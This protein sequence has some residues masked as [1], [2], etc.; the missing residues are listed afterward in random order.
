M[1][2][3]VS[4]R[5]ESSSVAVGKRILVL[6]DD[7]QFCALVESVLVEDGYDVVLAGSGAEATEKLDDSVSLAVVDGF[8]PDARGVE[9]IVDARR[10][11]PALPIIFVSGFLSDLGSY[12]TLTSDLSVA[13]VIY[14]PVPPQQIAATI[15][16]VLGEASSPKAKRASR[17]K[18]VKTELA[19]KLPGRVEALSDHVRAL[20]ERPDDPERLRVV[21]T[22]SHNLRGTA[23][24]LGYAAAGDAAGRIEDT[25]RGAAQP[26][27]VQWAIIDAAMDEVR[28]AVRRDPASPEL[29][30]QT[31]ASLCRILVVDDDA[32]FLRGLSSMARRSLVDIVPAHGADAAV[33]VSK[34][35]APDA[36]LID[37]AVPGEDTFQLA[38][39]LRELDGLERL[40]IGFISGTDS[41]LSRT[42]A[43]L[44][45]ASLFLPKPLEEGEFEQAVQQLLRERDQERSRVLIVDDDPLLSNAIARVLRNRG[46]VARTLNDPSLVLEELN[47]FAPHAMLLDGSMPVFSGYDVCRAVRLSARWRTLPILFVTG[48]STEYARHAAFASGGDDY[49]QKPVHLPEL[50]SRLEVRL[51][52]ARLLDDR[53]GRD[54]LSGLLSRQGFNDRFHARLSE[55]AR[56]SEQVSVCLIDLDRFKQVNDRH[57]HI[58]GDR[59]IAA[60]GLMLRRR[61]RPYDLRARWGGEEFLLALPGEGAEA[62]TEIVRRTLEEFGQTTFEGQAGNTFSVTFSA[63]VATYPDDG[64][65]LTQLI[66]SA[67]ERLYQAKS[68]GRRSVRGPG[69]Q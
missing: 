32:E 66:G 35:E 63:G 64:T 60:F 49:L 11:H 42:E 41:I 46:H 40:P 57:G 18:R 12:V 48:D 5:C 9:W 38:R 47:R 52:R 36:V 15:G 24:S 7:P 69:P 10:R 2:G 27:D 58:V 45:G 55:A 44:C 50:C 31:P 4:L 3:T 1:N 59:V 29:S 62:A 65:S 20:R 68:A 16:R 23:G 26:S 39:T 19:A 22:E 30:I 67:D 54:A 25:L 34:R 51:D 28:Q 33:E 8:L 61:L 43:A 6:D 37:V 56:R 53:T 13:A 17:L 21:I 14:K